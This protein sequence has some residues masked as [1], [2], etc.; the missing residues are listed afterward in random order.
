MVRSLEWRLG[1]RANSDHNL[2]E[3]NRYCLLKVAAMSWCNP[4]HKKINAPSQCH[5]ITCWP[6]P[7]QP[8]IASSLHA[9]A[10]LFSWQNSVILKRI[11]VNKSLQQTNMRICMWRKNI[12]FFCE[13]WG[14][15]LLRIQTNQL[16]QDLSNTWAAR[17]LSWDQNS[18]STT[19]KGKELIL[20]KQHHLSDWADSHLIQ[21]APAFRKSK[22][23]C[24]NQLRNAPPENIAR[25]HSKQQYP[26]RDKNVSFE[27]V[28]DVPYV[29]YAVYDAW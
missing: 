13:K 26:I 25:I 23:A 4:M 5:V 12:V 29:Y 3:C 15:K 20:T 28:R 14:E 22:R 16:R 6:T 18:K 10:A 21:S 17:N 9:L 2:M 1:L 27:N 7:P 8:S 11:S 24:R 19:G